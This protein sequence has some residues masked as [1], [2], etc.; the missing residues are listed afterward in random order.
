[1]ND[2]NRNGLVDSSDQ[3]IARNNTT[4]IINQ[5]KFLALGAGGPFAP[6]SSSSGTVTIGSATLGD[7]GIAS[8]LA[9]LSSTAALH[10]PIGAAWVADRISRM[11]PTTQASPTNRGQM[12]DN[13]ALA[14]ELAAESDGLTG[15]GELDEAV[16]DDLLSIT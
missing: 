14:L 6:E 2:F 5:L 8:G 13:R 1:V 3:I 4:T 11:V 16:L 15:A 7:S 12:V 9:G 10:P